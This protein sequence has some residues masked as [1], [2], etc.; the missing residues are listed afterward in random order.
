MAATLSVLEGGQS[1]AYDEARIEARAGLD[2]VTRLADEGYRLLAET[3]VARNL[4]RKIA[5]Y[6]V[7]RGLWLVGQ[8]VTKGRMAQEEIRRLLPDGAAQ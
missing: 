3:M 1:Q 2:E 7:H 5:E 6:R 4:N 8:A